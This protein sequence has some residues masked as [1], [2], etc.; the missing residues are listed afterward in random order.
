MDDSVPMMQAASADFGQGDRLAWLPLV[1]R[2]LEQ[3]GVVQ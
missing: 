3:T 2:S 1:I